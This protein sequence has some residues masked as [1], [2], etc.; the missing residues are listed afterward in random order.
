MRWFVILTVI[1]NTFEPERK[2][3]HSSVLAFIPALNRVSAL[4]DDS[5]LNLPR[6]YTIHR[7]IL[8]QKCTT[9][10]YLSWN[11][12][13]FH[14]ILSYRRHTEHLLSILL[15]QARQW[16]CLSQ[17]VPYVMNVLCNLS[18]ISRGGIWCRTL[19]CINP[20]SC[21]QRFEI[22]KCDF[23]LNYN[24]PDHCPQCVCCMLCTY[25]VLTSV[26]TD[27]NNATVKSI[28]TRPAQSSPPCYTV[29]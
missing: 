13:T 11:C 29:P 14:L 1:V 24:P 12:A 16:R 3:C 25:D 22:E 23:S 5:L 15:F 4:S 18:Y 27:K 6:Y 17:S 2:F 28:R 9:F 10:F 8:L 21:R 7:P 20:N 19:Y 26:I